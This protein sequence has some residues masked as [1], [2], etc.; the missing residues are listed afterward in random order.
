VAI[1]TGLAAKIKT[2]LELAAIALLMLGRPPSAVSETGVLLL[3]LALGIALA[4]L[5]RYVRR[6]RE[7][8]HHASR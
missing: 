7:P 3:A 8:L 1:G 6:N 5:P 4:T 2:A